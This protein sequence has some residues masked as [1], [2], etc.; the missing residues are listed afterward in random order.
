MLYREAMQLPRRHLLLALAAAIALPAQTANDS[1]FDVRNGDQKGKLMIR[2]GELQFE[3]LT[4]AKQSRTWKYGEIRS[5]E[6]RWRSGFRVR[7]FKGSRYDF[8]FPDKQQ[9]DKVYDLIAPKI[10]SA[11]T[12][13]K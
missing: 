10:L 5:F 2:D 12:N 13:T 1:M 8:Q 7:P 4:D 9:R 6:K 3:S 11:R